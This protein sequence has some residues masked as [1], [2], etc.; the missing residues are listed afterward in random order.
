MLEAASGAYR[1]RGVA[2]LS[3]A[4]QGEPAP[5]R[6]FAREAGITYPVGLDAGNT[7]ALRYGLVGLPTTVFI[8][9][10]GTIART[11]RGP[12][13]EGQLGALL[14]ELAR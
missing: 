9:R 6:A 11:W 8:A 14:D 4:V 12:L 1:D 13:T 7:I 3:V 10:D 2:V 5:A